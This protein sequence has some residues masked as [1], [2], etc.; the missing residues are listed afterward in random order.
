MQSSDVA[1]EAI[2]HW[3]RILGMDC[4]VHVW[5]CGNC[6]RIVHPVND[7]CMYILHFI[8]KSIR[9]LFI[10]GGKELKVKRVILNIKEC[11]HTFQY[12]L[13]DFPK[14]R[15]CVSFEKSF[16]VRVAR[17]WNCLPPELSVSFHTRLMFSIL[18]LWITL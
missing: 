4:D 17:H 6:L 2:L 18:N 16:V 9:V 7:I 10:N 12:N 15:W 5:P 1:T 14:L 11:K 8:Y 13:Y 3:A